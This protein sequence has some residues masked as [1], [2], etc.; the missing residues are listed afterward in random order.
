MNAPVASNEPCKY[1]WAQAS[2]A[3]LA[4]KALFDAFYAAEKQRIIQWSGEEGAS[5]NAL[6][7]ARLDQAARQ[8]RL[9]VS[10]C[11]NESIWYHDVQLIHEDDNGEVHAICI[12]GYIYIGELNRGA[13]PDKQFPFKK[14]NLDGGK[15]RIQ[16]MI[17]DTYPDDHP[18]FLREDGVTPVDLGFNDN[19]H[20]YDFEV[21]LHEDDLLD[22][23]TEE[24]LPRKQ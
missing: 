24:D 16:L 7:A 20:Y 17:T 23:F 5:D 21:I 4:E 14:E 18:F 2:A 12:G 11:K 19:D 8:R 9:R 6:I 3:A 22:E 10:R 13:H 1:S 15:V